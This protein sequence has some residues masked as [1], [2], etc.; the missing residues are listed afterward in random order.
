MSL[1]IQQIPLSKLIPSN[2]NVRRTNRDAGVK[3][4]AASI[5][6]HGLIQNLTVRKVV[7]GKSKAVLFEVV[8]GGRRLAALKSLVKKKAIRKDDRFPCHVL[9]GEIAEEIS[10]AENQHEPMHPADEYQAFAKLHAE[11]GMSAA[12]IAARFGVTAA[13]VKQRLKLGAVSPKLMQAYRDEAINLDTLMA[14]TLTDDHARQEEVYE[15][16]PR[17]NRYTVLQALTEGQVE[18]DDRRAVF[19]GLEAYRKAGGVITRDLFDKENGGYLADAD[20]LNRL[21]REKLQAVA[22][23]VMAEGWKWVTVEPEFDYAQTSSMRRIYPAPLPLPKEEQAKREV[24][25]TRGEAL[26]ERGDLSDE[27]AEELERIEAELEALQPPE[28]YSDEDKALAGAIVTLG[29][30]GETRIERG[31]VRREDEA[32]HGSAAHGRSEG[33]DAAEPNESRSSTQLSA[34]LAMELSA[35]RTAGLRNDL[36]QAPELALIAVT[37]ALALQLFRLE[38]S[39]ASCLDIAMKRADLSFIAKDID[40]S[41]AGR[42][43]A[44]R[45]AAWAKRLPRKEAELWAFVAALTMDDLLSLLAHCASLSL[46]VVQRPGSRE[47]ARLEHA[48]I[49]AKAMPHDMNRY[50]QA[51]A[52][53]FGRISREQIISAVREGA[54]EDA[55]RNIKDMKKAAMAENAAKLLDGKNW[56]PE[57]LR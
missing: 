12:D 5:E 21:V 6:A 30:D 33:S 40:E 22:A 3:E 54:G 35:Y 8:A 25:E 53:F 24:L 51:S 37:H 18:A 10:L 52:G 29:H 55:A 42:A 45:H 4:L 26:A 50:W 43:I 32:A 16:L 36:A 17:P 14:F 48:A 19:V 15:A 28:A 57:V 49:L 46:N 23:T 47:E 56:L 39:G 20:L 11:H 44:E 9:N 13:V 38:G 1:A 2:L 27:E 7:K 41:P 31:F 34:A